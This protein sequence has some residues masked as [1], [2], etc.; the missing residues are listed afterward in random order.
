L[1][2]VVVNLVE[3]AAKYTD[4][5]AESPSRSNM[6][7]AEAVL[8]VRDNGIGIATENLER[9]FDPFVQSHPPLAHPSSGLGLGSP[10]Y[11]E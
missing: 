5:A 4:R 6:R 11:G 7:D 10:W 2:Q 8:R 9:I 1:R 3:N